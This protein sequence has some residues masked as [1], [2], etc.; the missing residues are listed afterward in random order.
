MAAVTFDTLKFAEKLEAGGFTHSQAKAAAEAFAEATGQELAT[1]A[2]LRELE[3]RLK[4][5]LTLRLGGMIAAAVAI[6][7]ALMKLD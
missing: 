1:K 7:A 4:H 5:D 3:L 2:D 6:I